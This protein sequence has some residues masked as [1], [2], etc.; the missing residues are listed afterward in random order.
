MKDA[1]V[2]YRSLVAARKLIVSGIR[3]AGSITRKMNA[4]ISGVCSA[5]VDYISIVGLED[6]KPVK[7]ICGACL[8]ALAVRIGRIRLIDN[9]VIGA[10]I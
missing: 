2:L 7:K 4:M 9:M 5:K 6:L 3:D 10:R 1:L 8:V